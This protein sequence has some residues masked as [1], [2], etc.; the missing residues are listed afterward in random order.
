[1]GTKANR[2]A[3]PLVKTKFPFL[4]GLINQN[5]IFTLMPQYSHPNLLRLLKLFTA[6]N[7]DVFQYLI[8]HKRQKKKLCLDLNGI[9]FIADQIAPFM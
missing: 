6:H 3:S 4:L 7:C 2:D 9:I 1:M 5:Q 8:L